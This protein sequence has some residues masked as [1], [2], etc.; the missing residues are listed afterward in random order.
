MM[1]QRQPVCVT[2]REH[3]MSS[4]ARG[5]LQPFAAVTRHIDAYDVQRHG[6]TPAEIGTEI[7]PGISVRADT[8]VHMHG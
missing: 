7:G 6:T 5:S 3:R 8:V 1:C 2:I 4:P